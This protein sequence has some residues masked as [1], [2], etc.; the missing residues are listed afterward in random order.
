MCAWEQRLEQLGKAIQISE[1]TEQKKC[2]I[3]A[4]SWETTQAT[5]EIIQNIK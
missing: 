1:T 3:I 2:E 5:V 4:E